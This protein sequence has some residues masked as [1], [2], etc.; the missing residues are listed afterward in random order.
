MKV[1]S[2]NGFY[3]LHVHSGVA[4]FARI[5]DALDIG[6]WCEEQGMAGLV[7]KGHFESTVTRAH[8]AN[9]E[10]AEEGAAI[11]VYSSISLNRGVGGVNP[12]A[13]EIA[14]DMGAKVVWLPTVDAANH[15]RAYGSTGTYGKGRSLQF[16]RE[17]TFR[18]PYAVVD[19]SGRLTPEAKDVVDAVIAYD[20]ILATGHISQEEIYAVVDYALSK[21]HQRVVVTHP[22]F[23]V[24]N[25]SL[26]TMLDLARPGIYMEFCAANCLP[27]LARC[28]LEEMKA[29]IEA[30]GE[31][32]C[33]LSSDSGQAVH[34]RPPETLR[35]VVQALH[36]RGL[37]ETI[38]KRICVENP[39]FLLKVKG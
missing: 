23:V 9:R 16:R 39:A 20:A 29:M 25:L 15:A 22:E 13:V 31:S 14:L 17:S 11:K 12:G 2:I 28:S 36:D 10:L 8:H 37:S 33:I 21:N 38:I 3:D 24:P 4:P 1:L 5:G 27:F 32:R 30:V 7:V 19:E 34:P 35:S 26:E 18:T 6:R